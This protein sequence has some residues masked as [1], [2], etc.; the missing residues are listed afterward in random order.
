MG[1][2]LAD[3]RRWM[4]EGTA[5]FLGGVA[6]MSA[7]D[8]D[9]PSDLPGWTRK[10]VVSHVAANAEAIGNLVHWAATG[11]R[12]P[13]YASQEARDAGIEHGV[14]LPTAELVDW[15]RRSAE[16]LDAA[17]DALTE[18]Q[19]HHEVVTRQGR[20]IPATELPWMRA[21][22]VC[23]H[24]VDLGVGI[25]F[26]DL[27]TGFNGALSDEIRRQRGL[28]VLPIDLDTA[29]ID[30]IAAWLAGRSHRLRDAPDLGPWL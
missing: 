14:T 28:D 18:R 22:E 6:E 24:A 11:E 25:G 5:M 8:F 7:E 29:P 1:R 2:T 12:T 21:G 19:W 30:Q 13:M 23:V 27:P 20:T 10:H 3:N 26:A 4:A 16:T 15:L 9:E 17:M